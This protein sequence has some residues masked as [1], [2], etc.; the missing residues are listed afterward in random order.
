MKK[1]IIAV[2]LMLLLVALTG[3]GITTYATTGTGESAEETGN[4]KEET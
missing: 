2:V 4:E 1:K 3:T